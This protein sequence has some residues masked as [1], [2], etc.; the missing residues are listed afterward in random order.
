MQQ[1]IIEKEWLTIL[2][3]QS[4]EFMSRVMSAIFAYILHETE[5]SGLSDAERV[6]F[7]FVLKN[8]E[9]YQQQYDLEAGYE[10]VIKRKRSAEARE[11]RRLEKSARKEADDDP[12]LIVPVVCKEDCEVAPPVP[13]DELDVGLGPCDEGH[14]ERFRRF[15]LEYIGPKDSCEVEYARFRHCYKARLEIAD[16]LR[17]CLERRYSWVRDLARK[18][19]HTPPLPAMS[20]WLAEQ[21]WNHRLPAL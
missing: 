19:F 4:P 18:G 8:I 9:R 6:A 11:R 12:K 1:I 5:P 20:V 16:K 17:D 15:Y 2:E 21:G 7:E 14:Y 10:A 13:D 3:N